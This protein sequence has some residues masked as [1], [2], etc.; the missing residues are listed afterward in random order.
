VAEL[1]SCLLPVP[2]KK[3]VSCEND[4]DQNKLHILD[5]RKCN[6]NIRGKLNVT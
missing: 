6:V 2:F 5:R 4:N 1:V 3:M